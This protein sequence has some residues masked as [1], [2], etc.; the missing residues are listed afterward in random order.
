MVRE[1]NDAVV[2]G[3]NLGAVPEVWR[4]ITRTETTSRR[5]GAV[6]DIMVN[7]FILGK[8]RSAV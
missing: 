4:S 8:D 1:P 2:P 7:R 3:T 6:A 5:T